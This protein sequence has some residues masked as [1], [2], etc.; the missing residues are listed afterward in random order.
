MIAKYKRQAVYHPSLV[1][2]YDDLPNP[3][4]EALNQHQIVPQT[5]IKLPPHPFLDR[6]K[7]RIPSPGLRW[8]TTPNRVL[9]FEVDALTIAEWDDDINTQITQIPLVDT[10]EF[11]LESK[12]LHAW[13][14]LMWQINGS[15]GQTDVEFNS[16]GMEL[17]QPCLDILRQQACN[18]TTEPVPALDKRAL[19]LKFRNYIQISLLPGEEPLLLHYEP[20]I[21]APTWYGQTALTPNRLLALTPH[22]LIIVEDGA[23]EHRLPYRICRRYIPRVHVHRVQAKFDTQQASLLIE[24][25]HVPEPYQVSIEIRQ[26]V[27]GTLAQSIKRWLKT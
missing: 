8:C 13:L 16:V 5:I 17:I 12:L 24:V 4:A 10:I 23:H 21:Y 25:G 27:V 11:K 6:R 1:D 22:H 14:G 26:D 20:A 18:P 3:V 15:I 19:P 7:Q 9:I 2:S